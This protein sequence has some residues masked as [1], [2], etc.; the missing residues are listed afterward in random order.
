M[1]PNH[2]QKQQ[3]PYINDSN[4]S[5]AL[6]GAA[7]SKHL[8]SP[9]KRRGSGSLGLMPPNNDNSGGTGRSLSIQSLL[10]S[11]TPA[12]DSEDETS[13]PPSG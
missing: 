11:N 7:T 8:Y 1:Y 2:S 10:N 4:S 5:G 13:Q 6:S 12:T 3:Q 9:V